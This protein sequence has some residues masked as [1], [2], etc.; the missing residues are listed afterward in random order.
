MNSAY[1]ERCEL[2]RAAQRYTQINTFMRR[3]RL[4]WLHGEITAD[5]MINLRKTALE[6]GLEAAHKAFRALSEGE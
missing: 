3:V 6:Y 5:D 2:Q 4:T 1:L